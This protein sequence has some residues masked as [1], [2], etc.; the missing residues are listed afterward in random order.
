MMNK[1][2]SFMVGDHQGFWDLIVQENI[3]LIH[4]DESI[5]SKLT[6]E[7]AQEFMVKNEGNVASVKEEEDKMSDI[8]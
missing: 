5:K 8:E 6:L 2:K 7:Q 4:K 1:I 3:I